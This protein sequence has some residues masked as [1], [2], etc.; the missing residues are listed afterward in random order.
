MGGSQR[1]AAAAMPATRTSVPTEPDSRYCAK[2]RSSSAIEGAL[3]AGRGG[4]ALAHGF[5]L[6]R[7]ELAPGHDRRVGPTPALH[8][9]GRHFRHDRE[10]VSSF[11]RAACADGFRHHGHQIVK[12]FLMALFG[13]RR[14]S[15]WTLRLAPRSPPD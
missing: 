13:S 2:T 3:E 4:Q 12:L 15:L 8:L 14:F 10:R 7:D 9:F 6:A 11:R 5:Q 1:Q